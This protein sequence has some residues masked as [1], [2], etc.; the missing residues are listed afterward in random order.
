M[1]AVSGERGFTLIELLVVIAIIAI[2]AAMLLPALSRAKTK[3][4]SVQCASQVRQLG[5]AMRL[6]GD[7]HRERL[8]APHGSVPWMS[9]IPKPWL[10]PLFAYYNSTNLLTCAAA[11]QK[12]RQSPYSYFLGVRAIYAETGLHG[13]LRWQQIRY[14]AQYLLSGDANWPFDPS[15]AD[16]DNYSHDTLFDYSANLHGNA[17]NVLFGD[18]HVQGSGKFD[19]AAMTFA[20]VR[21][22]VPFDGFPG[23]P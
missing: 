9:Q 20:L 1:R 2:L 18:L 10:R 22:S 23:A 6:Y 4:R 12:H 3:A 16:P 14:P 21:Q 11:A 7:D 5:I 13:E 17:V 15:D 19:P 8:P